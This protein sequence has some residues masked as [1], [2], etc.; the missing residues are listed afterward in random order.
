MLITRARASRASGISQQVLNRLLLDPRVPLKPHY[1]KDKL[2]IDVS[3][4][5]DLVITLSD[6]RYSL[7]EFNH[8]PIDTIVSNL[9][10]LRDNDD[11]II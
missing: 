5:A 8:L 2:L 11:D 3:E 4:L 7:R 6:S 9:Y 10:P 1:E